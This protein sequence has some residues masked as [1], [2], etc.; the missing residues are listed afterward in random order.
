M[1]DTSSYGTS[2]QKGK[3]HPLF[4]IFIDFY[5]DFYQCCRSGIVY[6]GSLILIFPSRILDPGSKKSPDLTGSGCESKTFSIINP[7]T[8]YSLSE[9]LSGMFIPYPDPDFFPSRIPDPGVKNAPDP[10]PQQ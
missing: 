3:L 8:V 5:Q 9:K 4:N 10:D 1:S 7:K 2:R 6:T